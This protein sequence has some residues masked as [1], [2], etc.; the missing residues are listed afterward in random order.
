MTWKRV[1]SAGDVAGNSLKKFDVD[2][3]TVLIANTGSEF[4]AYPPLCPHMEED[5]EESGIC[6]GGLLTCSKHLWQW[7]ML[8]GE[9]RGEAE[10]PLL[11]Y[12]VKQ[13]ADDVL[14]NIEKELEYEYDEEE[15][16][17]DDSFWD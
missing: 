16:D 10:K 15:E 8:T 2:G 3:V 11:L 14:V 6:E 9:M 7:D 13:E 1:C 5:L 12:E 4:R 17:D